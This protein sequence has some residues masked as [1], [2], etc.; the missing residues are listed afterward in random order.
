MKDSGY[1]IPK[2]EGEIASLPAGTAFTVE[3]SVP[4]KNIALVNMS[5]LPK[6]TNISASV[7]MAKEG[8]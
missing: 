2:P 7:T 8:P 4:S 1:K 3:V 6:P 5:L